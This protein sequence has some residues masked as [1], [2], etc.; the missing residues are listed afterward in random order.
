MSETQNVPMNCD[1]IAPYYQALEYLSFGRSLERRRFASLND[2]KGSK[3]ALICGG[4]DGRFLARLLSQNPSVNVDFVD[5]SA[6]MIKLAE[7]RV[8]TTGANTL[9]RT[10]FCVGDIREF[11]PQ[12]NGY[13]LIVTNFFLDCFSQLEISRI[14]SLLASWAA[15]GAHW[16]IADFR[17]VD[18]AIRRIWS[19]YTIQALY[20]AFRLSTG[21][22]V[23]RL[24]N[25]AP[26]LLNAGFQCKQMEY[27]CG[28][29]LYS[30]LWAKADQV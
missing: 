16:I 2:V 24:A 13:D 6:N 7:R 17:E 1:G 26:Y 19:R 4:G 10:R 21:L 18:G 14:I 3:K 20:A 25:Y 30:S 23:R 9:A 27:G 5:L 22:Q 11:K 15:S 28:G 12:P 29:L 8:R